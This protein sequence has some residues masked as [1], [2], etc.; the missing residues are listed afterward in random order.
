MTLTRKLLQ[1]G[2]GDYKHEKKTAHRIELGFNRET[3]EEKAFYPDFAGKR[4]GDFACNDF[5]VEE[6]L[7]YADRRAA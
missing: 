5:W 7:I 4:N 3:N 1:N 2:G 6:Q